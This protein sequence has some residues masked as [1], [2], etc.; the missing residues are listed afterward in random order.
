M[1]WTDFGILEMDQ[2]SSSPPPPFLFTFNTIQYQPAFTSLTMGIFF[3][4]IK[5]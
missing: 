1:N 3:F 2:T 4:I 5:L